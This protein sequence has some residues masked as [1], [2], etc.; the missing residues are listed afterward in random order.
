MVR[1]AQQP[2]DAYG[3]RHADLAVDALD[4][5]ET[6]GRT[7]MKLSH[8]REQAAEAD[9]SLRAHSDARVHLLKG[10][11]ALGS[12]DIHMLHEALH[13]DAA[14]YAHVVESIVAMTH[15]FAAR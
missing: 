11:D 9:R 5:E 7:G 15:Y 10:P 12:E 2:A 1:L 8:M 14:G 6:V 4:R 13:P 3:G